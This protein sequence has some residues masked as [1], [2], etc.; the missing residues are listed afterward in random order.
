MKELCQRLGISTRTLLRKEKNGEL[1][2]LPRDARNGYR[3]FTEE[4]VLRFQLI[5]GR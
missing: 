2:P 1:P 4:D 3:R 5:L